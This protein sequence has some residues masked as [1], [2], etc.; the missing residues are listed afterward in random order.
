L[1]RRARVGSNG[2]IFHVRAAAVPSAHGRQPRA[3]QRYPRKPGEA[4]E[5]ILTHIFKGEVKT[6]SKGRLEKVEK[7]TALVEVAATRN[8]IGG[9][10]GIY[11]ADF[12]RDKTTKTVKDGGSTFYPKTWDRSSVNLAS[13]AKLSY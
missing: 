6:D 5:G 13:L 9:Y 10:A 4:T 3:D 2:Y 1:G 8:E 7:E 12:V 11:H